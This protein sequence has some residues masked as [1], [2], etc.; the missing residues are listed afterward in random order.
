MSMAVEVKQH[1]VLHRGMGVVGNI[2]ITLS[3]IT[4]A[5]SVFVIASVAFAGQ[6]SGAFLAFVAA[7]VI[8][9]GMAMS[10]AELGSMYPIAGGDYSI[11]ARV[12][13]RFLGFLM[14]ALFLTL[15]IFIPSAIAL[16]G[17][18]YLAPLVAG[19]NPNLV[20]ALVMAVVTAVALLPIRENAVIT[21][22]FLAIELALILAVVVLGLVHAN[23]LSLLIHPRVFGPHG[24]SSAA[25]IGVIASGVTIALFS[26]NGYNSAIN[27]SEETKGHPQDIAK[28]VY[29]AFV[30]A[31]VFELTP[32]AA[33]VLGAP[34]LSALSTAANPFSYLITALTNGTVNKVF[35]LGV[36]LAVINAT[37]AIVVINARIIYSS[38]RD[39]AWPGPV[40]DW[41]ALVH[42]RLKS[43]WFATVFIGVVG[44]LLTA[45]TKVAS[46]VTFTGVIVGIDY[47][48][49]AICA[50]LSRFTRRGAERPYR[51]PLW[52]LP[53]LLGLAG[54][55]YALTQQTVHDLLIALAILAG[56]AI[57]Y[58]GYLARRPGGWTP[59]EAAEPWEGEAAEPRAE[60]PESRA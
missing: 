24:V 14:F 20:G 43:P 11:T 6:G 48:L 46:L 51:M 16:G 41:M 22:I 38:G 50:I 10:W 44:T 53:P 3:G 31:I 33:A 29:L 5:V 27:L 23:H 19:A 21:G 12:L 47:A 52:P 15:A 54:V 35:S 34:S 37:L 18:N 59:R 30:L 39:R 13:G 26:Y 58:V 36:F 7:A 49:I 45:L 8:G 55:V 25:T 9:I 4:P 42:H 57:Y 60:L 32:V 17:A 1:D 40:S 56:A 28:A 2:L